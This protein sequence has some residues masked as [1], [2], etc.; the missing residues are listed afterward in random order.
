MPKLILQDNLKIKQPVVIPFKEGVSAADML[1]SRFKSIDLNKATLHINDTQVFASDNNALLSPLKNGDSVTLVSEVKGFIGDA[2]DFAL[3]V[4]GV[5]AVLGFVQDLFTPDLPDTGETTASPNNSLTSQTNLIR[6]YAQKALVC[7]SPRIYPD[8]IGEPVEYYSNNVK[9]SESYFYAAY[10]TL[11]GGTV[12]AGETNIIRF[13]GATSNLYYPVSGITTVPDYRVGQEVDEIDG[14]TLKGTNEGEDGATISCTEGPTATTYVGTTFTNR[15]AQDTDSDNLKAQYDAGNVDV[16]IQ[17]TSFRTIEPG[18]VPEPVSSKGT[19]NI[20]SF[21]LSGGEYEVVVSNFNGPKSESIYEGPYI[22]TLKLDNTLGPFTNPTQCEKMFFNIAFNRGLKATVPITVVVYE[23]DSKGGTRTGVSETFSISYTDDIVDAQYKTF[24][25]NIT[26]G[27]SWYEWTIR[28]TNEATQD[29]SEPDV[30]TLEKVFCIKEIGDYDFFN[31]TM[32]KT[33]MNSTQTPTSSGV[34]NKINII[35]AQVE[36]PS[37]NKATSAILDN[38]P[39]RNLADAAMFVWHDFHGLDLD[40]LDLDE[41]YTIVDSLPSG[42]ETFDYTFD[43]VSV[44]AGEKLDIILN[45]GRIQKYW[46][47]KKVRFWRDEKVNF[48]SAL[49]SRTDIASESER[50]YSISRSSFVAGE[51]DSVQVEYVNREINKKAYV[52]RSIDSSGNI[53]NVSGSNPKTITLA[54]CQDESNATNRAEL[55]IRR[56]LYQRW[57]LSDTFMNSQIFLGKGDVVLYNEVY[58]GGNAW[59]GEIQAVNGGAAIN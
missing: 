57:S 17:Y 7:G 39:S 35:N 37:Y 50:S 38:S 20:I 49:L 23:L 5:G 32:L 16:E 27:R 14:Q 26:N 34:D 47:G 56:M 43:D 19:G 18:G 28:R 11:N 58:E 12:Q 45:V 3:D 10:G 48:N 6:A 24:E 36:M 15:L 52:Y 40:L 59:G 21:T 44:S 22:Y 29:T 46:D 55:E 54:G 25:T 4:T 13:S 1:E 2:I 33:V 41:L 53:V 8:L 30:P 31:A 9:Y 51:Y 42:F